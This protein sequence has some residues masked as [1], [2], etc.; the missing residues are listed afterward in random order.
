MIEHEELA[1]KI[2][3]SSAHSIGNDRIDE[4]RSQCEVHAEGTPKLWMGS[5]QVCACGPVSAGI[6]PLTGPQ[7]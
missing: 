2:G 6:P 7:G 1:G 4:I 3:I 5:A